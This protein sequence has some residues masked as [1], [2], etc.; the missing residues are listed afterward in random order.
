MISGHDHIIIDATNT[1][2][3]RRDEW[4]NRFKDCEIIITKS[5]YEKQVCVDRARANNRLDLVPVIQRMAEEYENPD[6]D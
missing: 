1:T 4:R 5:I 6:Y 2:K 3:K